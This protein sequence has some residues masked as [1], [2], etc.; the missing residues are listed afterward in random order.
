MTTD[1][2]L[3]LIERILE[4]KAGTLMED[5]KLT[6]LSKWD[7]LTILSLQVELTALKPDVQF[8]RLYMC[9]TVGDICKMI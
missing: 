2:K 9:K 8:D 4:V 6:S 1:E 7:S 5:T 3:E